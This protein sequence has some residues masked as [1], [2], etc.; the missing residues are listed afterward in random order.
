MTAS[1]YIPINRAQGFQFLHILINSV[2]SWGLD[3]SHPNGCE[4]ISHSCFHLHFPNDKGP[5]TARRS[6]QSI[7]K[8]SPACSLEGM[9]LKLKLQYFGCLMR[10]VDSL[11]KTLMLGGIGGRRR[12]GRQRMRWLGGITGSMDMS[13][14]GLRE[15]VMDR[16]A[17]R[18]AIHGV[19]KSR[20]RL[21]D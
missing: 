4:V 16:E 19:T 9:M 2:V 20:I 21:S 8:I 1:F 6:S 18:A 5:W 10:R 7:L 11:E 14:S 17:W 13:L 15:L 3:S 12:R